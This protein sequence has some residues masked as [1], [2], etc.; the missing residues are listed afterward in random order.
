MPKIQFEV[1]PYRDY[2][3]DITREY[4]YLALVTD[5]KEVLTKDS[6]DWS[7]WK[8]DESYRTYWKHK[9]LSG[10]RDY[11][12]P[13]SKGESSWRTTY[14]VE[15]DLFN[16]WYKWEYFIEGEDAHEFIRALHGISQHTTDFTTRYGLVLGWKYYKVLKKHDFLTSTS[17]MLA[18]ARG[19]LGAMEV[20][21]PFD[22]EGLEALH[23][24]GLKVKEGSTLS[25]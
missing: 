16:E 24:L 22:H 15:D 23:C 12:E 8:R 18:Y 9:M 14:L 10:F 2:K 7:R 5:S 1:R 6:L 21:R 13:L 11:L 19:Y 20:G 4:F 17:A 25:E 3:G